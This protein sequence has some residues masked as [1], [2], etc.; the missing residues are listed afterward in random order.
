VKIL[1][2]TSEAAPLM[3]TGGLAD[4]SSSLPAALAALGHDVRIL[5][6]AY[7]DA[8]Q[9]A[10]AL[11]Q[12]AT[13]HLA[14]A[15]APVGILET[16]M[17][18]TG[19]ATWLVDYPPFFG[20]AGNPYIGP[21][22]EEWPD[23]PARFALLGRV[24]ATIAQGGSGFVWQPEVLHCNDWQT[25]LAPALLASAGA[26]PAT[27][28][29]IHNLAYQGVY[30]WET[31]ASL[32]LPQ[33]LWATDGLEYYGQ[34]S[35]IKGALVFADWLTTVSPTYA[36]EIQ[37]PAF[38]FGLDGLLRHRADR[39]RGILNGADYL[40]WDPATDPL[41]SAHFDAADLAG[42]RQ[43]KLA[44]LAELELPEEA[45]TPLLGMIT[46]LVDQ[47]GVDLAIDALAR[48]L[49]HPARLV[50]LGSGAREYEDAL[51]QLAAR[52]PGQVAVRLGYDESLAHRIESGADMF[53]MPS[54]FE[55]C[56]LNQIYSLRYGTLPVVRRTGGLADTV[57]DAT[58][59]S[60]AAGTATGFV[61][62]EPSAE[63]L[64]RTIQRALSVYA[65]SDTWRSMMR[66]AMAQDFSWERSAAQYVELYQQALARTAVSI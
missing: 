39:L 44:L 46:R 23:N 11:A 61:F 52:F 12:V 53:L 7:R 36:Q 2:A 51:R 20:R 56:G 19:V 5:M 43:N 27:L 25:A 33:A 38:G 59:E 48:V 15:A 22:K 9:R 29:T 31:F 28:F 32:G 60:V 65:D 3:K 16:T 62:D 30:P 64:G 4:V 34:M 18:D 13:L 8:M 50:A 37:T 54:R 49:E 40:A 17:P 63:A 6:P 42:K 41:I 55:P 58:P 24:A 21:D 14:G 10:G 66:A 47:K 26:R 1:F 35:F 57:V 45:D